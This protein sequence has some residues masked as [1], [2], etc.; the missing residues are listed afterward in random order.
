M[1]VYIKIIDLILIIAVCTCIGMI[2]ASTFN[3]RVIDLRNFKSALGMFKSK[4]EFTYEPLNVIFY[5]IS[6]AIYGEKENVFEEFNRNLKKINDTSLAWQSAVDKISFKSCDKEIIFML[7][8]M[9]GKTD[10][11]GQLSEINLIDKFIDKQ[12][13]EAIIEKQ[14]N[15]KLYRT[16]GVTL[17]IT[18]ALILV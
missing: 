12:I 13:E 14:K 8:K 16:L 5:E 10:K 2:K 15:E 9:L 3:K 18:I 4:I 1:Y 7:G 17:G 6:K 11:N